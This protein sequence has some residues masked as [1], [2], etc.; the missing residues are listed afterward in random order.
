MR[1]CTPLGRGL[2]VERKRRASLTSLRLTNRS[3]CALEK[4]E[5]GTEP[6]ED[7]DMSPRTAGKLS[8]PRF[9]SSHAKLTNCLLID[10][11][12]PRALRIHHH[13][14]LTSTTSS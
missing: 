5:D 12:L 3:S 11:P 9:R 13:S 2:L 10:Q 7:G 8:P 1:A 6:R 14:I 4:L